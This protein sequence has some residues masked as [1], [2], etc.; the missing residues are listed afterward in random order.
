MLIT[1]PFTN[2]TNWK[3]KLFYEQD[4]IIPPQYPALLNE[5]FR[6]DRKKFNDQLPY[7]DRSDPLYPCLSRNPVDVQ[8][9]LE[10]ILFVAGLVDRWEGSPL[11]PKIHYE[12]Q[13]MYK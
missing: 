5:S 13:S 9:F 8:T 6:F 3:G 1:K 12:G 10:P 11:L 4:I 2:K 7:S